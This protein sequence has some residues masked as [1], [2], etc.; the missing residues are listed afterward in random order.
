[1]ASDF[2]INSIYNTL[3]KF[4][5]DKNFVRD[6]LLPDWWDDEIV[7]TKAGYLQTIDLISKNLGI[8]LASFAAN[9]ETLNLKGNAQIKFKKAKNIEIDDKLI[10][11]RSLAVRISELIEQIFKVDFKP[12]PQSATEIRNQII[13]TSQK[14]NL[15]TLLDYL[16]SIG[17]PVLHVSE[18][19]KAVNKMDGMIMNLTD[20]PIIIIS[21]NR[22]HDAWLL[23]IIAHELGHFIKRHLTK[24]GNIIYD[25][26]IEEEQ[27]REEKEAN[28]FALDLLTGNTTPQF[29]ISESIDNSFKLLNHV[30]SIS[31]RTNIDPGVIVLNYAYLTKKWALAEQ[32]LKNL[33]PKAD[34][35]RKIKDKIRQNLNFNN[36]TEENTEF[37]LRITSLSGEGI[38]SIS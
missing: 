8:D 30:I 1:M 28:E 6:I 32:T 25:T 4:G 7:R 29:H 3:K 14:L 35:V 15:E 34:A 18:F 22:K 23:F 12:L 27:D 26:D 38:A 19:P 5:I 31:K 9:L 24:S 11:P 10:W 36:I 37:F 2:N 16:W 21:K 20:R 33:N 17:I 13:D